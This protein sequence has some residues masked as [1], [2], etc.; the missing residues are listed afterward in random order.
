MTEY[1]QYIV[2]YIKK[3]LKGDYEA[4]IQYLHDCSEKY[5]HDEDS[6]DIL[7]EIATMM[8]EILPEEEK[9]QVSER[10]EELNG[11]IDAEY[12]AVL[13]MVKCG[14]FAQAKEL[15]HTLLLSVENRYGEDEDNLYL[16]LNHVMELYEYSYFQKPEK[17]IKTTDI[18]YNEYYRTY[19]V[20]LMHLKEYEAAI[21]AHKTAIRW[22]PVDLDSYLSLGEVYKYMGGHLA[23]F[24]EVTKQAHRYC[25]TRATMARYYRNM[26]FYYL[27]SYKPD[28]ARAMYV[29]SNIYFHTEHADGELKYIEEAMKTPTP[30]YDIQTLQQ[31]LEENAVELGPNSE[32]IG[33][34]YRVGKLLLESK[35]LERARDCF[36]I[37]YDITQ[38]EEVG[39]IL[40]QLMK[41]AE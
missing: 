8:Y 25:C 19:G 30:E 20:I 13:D 10:L 22:N 5:S 23:E 6:A 4:D 7:R 12:A 37:V 38:D 36:T 17:Q 33:V 29:Y 32:T 40:T 28:A 24:L 3:N 18:Q 35:D 27:E 2:D 1:A 26:G 14:D 16:S 11:S 9:S 31:I 39:E 41:S 15:M 21:E 34:I